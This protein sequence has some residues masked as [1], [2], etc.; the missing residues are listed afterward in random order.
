MQ[1][2]NGLPSSGKVTWTDVHVEVNNV[3]VVDAKWVAQEE[4]PVCGS[5]AVVINSTTIG[6][7]WQA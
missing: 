2:C 7:E 3:K 4:Q 1:N 6:I 5:K